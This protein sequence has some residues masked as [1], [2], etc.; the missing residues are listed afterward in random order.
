MYYERNACE[1]GGELPNYVLLGVER[2]QLQHH[3]LARN[4]QRHVGLARPREPR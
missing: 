2:A 3:L 1:R 4:G